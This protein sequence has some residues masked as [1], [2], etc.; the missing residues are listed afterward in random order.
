MGPWEKY[1]QDTAAS[2]TG[3]WDKY[4]A[5]PTVKPAT[6]LEKLPP[7]TPAPK[8]PEHAD[9]I[10]NKLLGIGEAGLSVASSIP[11][12]IAG[13]VYGI[14][15][16]LTSG[17]YGTQAGI[18]EGEKAGV[19]LANRMTYQPRT[20]TGRD[21]VEGA[22]RAMDA[23]RL[24]GLPV[25]G[26]ML[27]RIPEVP[28]GVLAAGEGT[29]GAARGVGQVAGRAAQGV[30]RAAVN[31]LPDVDPQT[32]QL[33]RQ[34]H[35]MGFRLTPDMVYGNKYA[36]GA[37]ELAQ[38][39]PFVGKT[40]R[41]HNQQVFNSH[42]VNAIGG[43]GDKLTRKTFAEAMDRSGNTIGSIA[44]KYPLPI[45]QSFVAKLREN[46]ANQ[47]PEVRG[48]IEKYADQI[49]R[50]AG[51]P[52]KLLGGGRT[53]A[54]RELPGPV[55]RR[56][57]TALSK[58]IRGT[59]NG[60]LR[61]ALLGLQDDLLEERSKY[62]SQSDL[63]AYNEARRQYA[64]GSALEPLVAKS[65][66]GNVSPAA[67]LGVVTKNAAGKSAMARG[68]AGQMGVLADIS[69]RFLKEQPSSGTAERSLM[70]NL[71]THPIGALAAGGTAALTAPV[72]AAYNRYSPSVT[73]MLIERP[74]AP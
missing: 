9:S 39:N 42:L 15:K 74:P 47:L 59:T 64:I 14:G 73:N 68:T 67:L 66:T 50:A 27:A 62:M 10:A 44:E 25:E 1:A 5:A 36:R 69:Q 65:A 41:E 11:A 38:D 24:Q 70:Q 2:T 51:K 40:V 33:A 34:A 49:D 57:N 23:S 8:A 26:P 3:P 72:A 48:V 60:D 16:T 22:G 28:R 53:A 13:Q 20:Q 4:G 30:G 54:P 19:D 55:F 6:G 61:T 29:A 63:D 7:D 58:Q 45:D 21:L 56:I 37:G 43:E 52:E 71:L 32:L 18:Q 31:Q 35:S 17:K 46:G 12:G